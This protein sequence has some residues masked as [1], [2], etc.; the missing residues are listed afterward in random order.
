QLSAERKAGKVPPG[1]APPEPELPDLEGASPELAL[2][3]ENALDAMDT[4][5]LGVVPQAATHAVTIDLCGVNVAKQ[6]HVGHLRATLIGDTLA[7][8]HERLGRKVWRENHLG[9]W[10]LPIAMAKFAWKSPN[11][12]FPEGRICG[13]HAVSGSPVRAAMDARNAWP[14]A[15]AGSV[16]GRCS[17]GAAAGIPG[18]IWGVGFAPPG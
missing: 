2:A 3:L 1:G 16:A 18:R 13:S 8:V 5:A 12:G 17:E 9:D 14:R 6:M 10:G 15:A 7:R 11:C 4:P